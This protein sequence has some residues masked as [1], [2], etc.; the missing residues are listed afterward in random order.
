MEIMDQISTAELLGR[1]DERTKTTALAVD[2]VD[3]KIEN[4]THRLVAVELSI[5]KL[6]PVKAVV[7]GLIGLVLVAVATAVIAVVVYK[8]SISQPSVQ[9][10][11]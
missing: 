1:I 8:P 5:T 7:Y 6:Q 3:S 9:E 11:R 2:R 4:F 10:V